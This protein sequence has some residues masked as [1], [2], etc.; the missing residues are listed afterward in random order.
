MDALIG[1]LPAWPL[2]ADPLLAGAAAL[3]VAVLGGEIAHR[4]MRLPRITGYIA[5]GLLMGA[6]GLGPL[7][8]SALGPW[9]LVVDLAL[10]LL[11]FECGMRVDFRWFRANP[12]LLATSLL[13]A[14]LSFGTVFLVMRLFDATAWLAAAVAAITMATSPAVAMRVAAEC[15]A[16]GQVTDRLMV[17]S[18][19]N[20]FY[21][22]VALELVTGG[23]HGL[24]GHGWVTAVLHP[25]QVI[26]GPLLVAA[27]MARAFCWLRRRFDFA[28]EQG[29]ALLFGLLLLGLVALSAA[30]LPMLLAPLL[31]GAMVRHADPRPRTWPRHFGT[32]GGLLVILLFVLTG[33]ALFSVDVIAGGLAAAVL[34]LTRAAGKAAG[35]LLLG[36]PSGLSWRQSGALAL[37]LTPMSGVALVMALD[38]RAAFPDQGDELA[39][40]VFGAIALLGLVGPFAVQLA[41]RQAGEAQPGPA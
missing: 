3:I 36:R 23:V 19:L 13:E 16:S 18:A 35:V 14:L 22:I 1:S 40:V 32:V 4:L 34:V 33:V 30:R 5:V 31:A 24:Q 6:A 7:D 11:L 2:L 12:A 37:A 27:V 20:V 17:L 10:A 8:G 41:L 29:T 21:A 38:F 28:D 9:R 25:V 39:A 26:A 15:R